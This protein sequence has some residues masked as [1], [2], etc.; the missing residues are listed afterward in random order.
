MTM[1]ALGN[2]PTVLKAMGNYQVPR[3]KGQEQ[4]SVKYQ[5]QRAGVSPAC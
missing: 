1:H 3:L 4:E 2:M 5:C